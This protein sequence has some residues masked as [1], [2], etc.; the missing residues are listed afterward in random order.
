MEAGVWGQQ[1][2]QGEMAQE[3]APRSAIKASAVFGGELQ[4]GT[5]NIL[6]EE[7]ASGE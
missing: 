1:L 2:G 5:H 3:A 7:P 6:N 4:G